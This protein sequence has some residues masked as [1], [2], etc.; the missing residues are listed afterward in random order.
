MPRELPP[1]AKRVELHT[2]NPVN[3][4]IREKTLAELREYK[5]AGTEALT[6]RIRELDAE[7]DTERVLETSA[8]LIILIG[9]VLAVT[10]SPYWLILVLAV[11]FFLLEHAV[12]GWC[13]PLPLIR[14]LGVRTPQE[15]YDEKMAVRFLRGDF[16][17]MGSA[18]EMLER[19]HED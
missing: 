18:E 17:D 3:A 19:L 8:S 7:W 11:S 12:Q 10:V 15:I 2:I 13:P 14:R 9:T 5:D 4:R 16:G 1:T 6:G